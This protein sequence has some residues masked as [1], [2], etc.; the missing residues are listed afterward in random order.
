MFLSDTGKAYLHIYCAK[1]IT[2]DNQKFTELEHIKGD[3]LE[4]VIKISPATH[5]VTANYDMPADSIFNKRI[6]AKDISIDCP[7][8]AGQHYIVAIYK[9]T[10][11]EAEKEENPLMDYVCA[12]ELEKGYSICLYRKK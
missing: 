6:K 9:V 4:D 8:E 7:V 2:V 12:V 5:T 3:D 11:E 10:P 1:N